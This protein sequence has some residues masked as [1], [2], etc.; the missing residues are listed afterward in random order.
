MTFK[1]RTNHSFEVS[2]KTIVPMEQDYFLAANKYLVGEDIE[3]PKGG[4]C[5]GTDTSV[6]FTYNERGT[7]TKEDAIRRETAAQICRGCNIRAKCLMYSLEYEPF[8]IWGGFHET[9]R[10][11]LA[12]FWN[13]TPKRSWV[14]RASFI[15]HR[16]VVDYITYPE[17]ISFIK[18][19]AHDNNLAQPPFDERPGLPSSARRRIRPRVAH[20]TR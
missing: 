6:F 18:K 3:L 1:K 17:D 19:V 8:G 7:F 4:A 12:K 14:G 9:T 13:I 2:P 10:L 11:I 5:A 20:T 16:T 15:R